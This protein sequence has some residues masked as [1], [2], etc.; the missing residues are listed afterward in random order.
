VYVS[1]SGSSFD[2]SGGT[3]AGNRATT[4][5]GGGVYVF[6]GAFTMQ[7]GTIAGN[8]ATQGGGVSIEPNSSFTKTGGVIYG[9]DDATHTPG[10]A[11]NTAART[12]PGGEVWGHAVY[13]SA[14]PGYYRNATLGEGDNIS[15]TDTG[16]GWG[17]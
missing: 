12:T 15:T 1:G 8:T 11:E 16:T 17:Q 10:S 13:Y 2:M 6:Y 9:D 3:I 5:Y 14:S 4:G 7:G